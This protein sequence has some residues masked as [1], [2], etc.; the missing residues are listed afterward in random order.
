MMYR[1]HLAFGLLGAALLYPLFS[2]KWYVYFPLAA[3]GSLLPDGDHPNSYIGRRL[4]I[5]SKLLN[6]LA[7]HRGVMHSIW[8]PLLIGILIWT[9]IGKQF[10][11]PLVLGYMSHLISDSLTVQGINFIHPFNKF[12]IAGFIRTGGT[13]EMILFILILAFAAYKVVGIF[14]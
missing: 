8:V 14:L 1:T 4:G 12:H 11:I 7:G 6:F 10:A 9:S 5:F 2:I 13:M 3:L